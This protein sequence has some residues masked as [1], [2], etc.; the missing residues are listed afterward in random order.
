MGLAEH[1]AVR[2]E[3]TQ[4]LPSRGMWLGSGRSW[5]VTACS[6]HCTFK[7]VLG[8]GDTQD[9]QSRAPG[10]GRECSC[11]RYPRGMTLR[12]SRKWGILGGRRRTWWAWS[13]VGAQSCHW[14]NPEG[15]MR[16]G[17]Q[18]RWDEHNQAGKGLEYLT[19]LPVSLGFTPRA[20]GPREECQAD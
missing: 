7:K 15:E 11:R 16:R 17:Q 4:A 6:G 3:W 20:W 8:V 18:P 1:G 5:V 2:S 13:S 12:C 19:V 9:G 14:A 10:W